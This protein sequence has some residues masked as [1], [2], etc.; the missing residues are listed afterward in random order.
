MAPKNDDVDLINAI[1]MSCVTGEGK[2]YKSID[3]V[4]KDQDA[5]RCPQEL[6]NSLNHPGVPP[7]KLVLKV[8]TPVMVL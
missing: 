2:I 6:L 8:N 3:K 7:Q 5:T 4:M 1:L